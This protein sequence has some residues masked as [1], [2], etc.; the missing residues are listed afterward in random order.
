MPK[1]SASLDEN[2]N[3][4]IV[5]SQFNSEITNELLFTTQERLKNYN[6]RLEDIDVFHVPGVV[7]IPIILQ[8]LAHSNKYDAI[9]ALGS[10]IRGE[11]THYDYVCQQ[12]SQGCHNIMLSENIPI[13]FGILTTETRQQAIDRI[14]GT[15]SKK[16]E[17]FA[18]ATIHMI[19]L[20]RQF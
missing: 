13:I 19:E 6:F 14:D 9:I 1:L 11:T 20:I 8:N 2:Y 7:E 16:G 12:V 3:V 4:A 10:V 18:D 5:V 15:H 17:E